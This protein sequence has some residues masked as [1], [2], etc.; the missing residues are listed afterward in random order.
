[1]ISNLFIAWK[2][3]KYRV[4]SGPYFDKFHAMINKSYEKKKHLKM[5]SK[6]NAL[7]LWKLH[8]LVFQ[9]FPSD[10]VQTASWEGEV[11]RQKLFQTKC[12]HTKLLKKWFQSYLELKNEC[13]ELLKRAFFSFL[14]IF[15]WRS[16]NRIFGR[17]N[18]AKTFCIKSALFEAF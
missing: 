4:F 18:A 13:S 15:E 11:K 2:V 17:D 3:S 5:S 14:E 1:M 12:Y 6:T 16:W 10:K 8:F 9:K 7:N